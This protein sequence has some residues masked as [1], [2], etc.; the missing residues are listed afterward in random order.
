MREAGYRT[1]AK[2]T[3]SAPRII[4]A[5]GTEIPIDRQ[6]K[7]ADIIEQVQV[8]KKYAKKNYEALVFECM[9]ILPKY[10]SFLEQNV[11]QSQIGIITNVREDHVEEMGH[12]LE[13]IAVSLSKTIPT[14]G[15]LILGEENPI[16]Q[17]V[18]IKEAKKL[19]TKVILADSSEITKQELDQFS[20]FQHA[21]NI[22][23]GYALA[24]FYGIDRKVALAGMVKAKADVGNFEIT[25]IAF[26]E[27]NIFWAN[28][29]AIN[30]RESFVKTCETI[31]EYPNYLN[32]KKVIILNNRQDRPLRVKQFAEISSSDLKFDYYITFGSYENEVEKFLKEKNASG[33]LIK[34]SGYDKSQGSILNQI[35]QKISE[36]E[37]LLV[38]S[39]NIHTEQ[40]DVMIS[41]INKIISTKS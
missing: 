37:F 34:M 16:L 13:E 5:D 26:E 36:E 12:T 4:E 25:K 10:Q 23:I 15:I 21:E 22:A 11:M 3:G 40:A 7:S 39:T 27:K 24:D 41:E 28:L 20:Y 18:I 29:F 14:N 6:G 2:T 17:Q 8:I 30:D 38:G 9:A 19:N 33:K 31:F 32:L 35:S 1:L